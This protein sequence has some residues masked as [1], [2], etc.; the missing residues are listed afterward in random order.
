MSEH[1]E[2]NITRSGRPLPPK[3]AIPV[4]VCAWP[5]KCLQPRLVSIP[6]LPAA[7]RNLRRCPDICAS[8][9]E[10][11]R[12]CQRTRQTKIDFVRIVVIQKCMPPRPASWDLYRTFLGVVREGNLTAAARRLGL[13]QPTAGRHIAALESAVGT[14]L[15]T[16]SPRGLLADTG[17][18]R[19]GA[20]YRS[21][22]C[23]R[24]CV[25]PF[26]DGRSRRRTRCRAHHSE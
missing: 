22:G 13:T 25:P 10:L 23:C 3:P 21:H 12:S 16:R 14:A 26:H 11:H 15:F 9:F 24:G 5:R 18:P 6:T 4:L 20:A 17:R 2:T 7:T 19:T 1:V 8:T